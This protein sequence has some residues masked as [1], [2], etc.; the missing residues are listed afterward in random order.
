MVKDVILDAFASGMY[1]QASA[2]LKTEVADIRTGEDG[3]VYASAGDAV[4][5]QISAVK[6]E[7]DKHSGSGVTREHAAA[8]DALLNCIAYDADSNYAAAYSNFRAV[9]GLDVAVSYITAVAN[10]ATASEGTDARQLDI[11]VTAYYSDGT[12]DRVLNYAIAGTVV[13]GEN[14]FTISYGGKSTTVS[15]TG[16]GY[17]SAPVI[18]SEDC[19]Q[20]TTGSTVAKQGLCVTKNYDISDGFDS[21][22]GL[23][24]IYCITNP[25][26]VSAVTPFTKAVFKDASGAFTGYFSILRDEETNWYKNPAEGSEKVSFTLYSAGLATSFAYLGKTG[27]IVFAGAETQYYG[28]RYITD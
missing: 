26:S 21:A 19:G 22:G 17:D 27:R 1:V 9:F 3:T 20:D 23:Q 5:E 16:V 24:I 6:A 4:R 15:V 7:I 13:L 28:K 18:V 12:S 11:T 25:D 8:L 2:S 10:S 14:T